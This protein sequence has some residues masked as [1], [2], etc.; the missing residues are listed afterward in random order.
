MPRG[1]DPGEIADAAASADERTAA[2]SVGRLIDRSR[3]PGEVWPS[4]GFVDRVM[5][6]V[7]LEPVH[8]PVGAFVAALR[9]GRPFAIVAAIRDSWRIAT[10]PEP[11]PAGARLGAMAVVL[12]TMLA[13]GTLG[14]LTV[15]AARYLTTAPSP[16]PAPLVSPSPRPLPSPSPLPAP[17]QAPSPVPTPSSQPTRSTEPTESPH[18]SDGGGS[19]SGGSGSGSAGSGSGSGGSTV[20]GPAATQRPTAFPTE[21]PETSDDHGG[22][23]GTGPDGP[24]SASPTPS[25]E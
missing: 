11:R 6:A 10:A 14:G 16:T 15:G 19:S 22:S 2:A 8:R 25:G 24:G 21:T 18:G 17:S 13:V 12:A 7:A 3:E 1:F 20:V 5:A 9:S 23:P 4:A